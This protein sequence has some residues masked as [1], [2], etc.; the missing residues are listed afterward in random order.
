[1]VVTLLDPGDFDPVQTGE[2]DL[3]LVDVNMPQFFG[4]DVVSYIKETWRLPAPVLLFSNVPE[5][6]LADAA[7]RCGADGYI[8]KHKGLD[9]MVVSVRD[10]LMRKDAPLAQRR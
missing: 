4:D 5:K 6:E 3:I 8:S 7:R 10:L 9:A 2:P 1:M